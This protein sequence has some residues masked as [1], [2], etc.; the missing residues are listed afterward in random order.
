MSIVLESILIVLDMYWNTLDWSLKQLVDCYAF[1]DRYNRTRSEIQGLKRVDLRDYPEIA[2]REALLNA[3]VHKD[4]A[5]SS[6]ILIS[7][8]EDR[9]EI[10][11]IGGLIKGISADDLLLGI[12][13]LRNQYLADV[14]YRLKWV[15]AYG[16]GI[17][18]IMGSY[19]THE[20]TPKIEV[21][22]NV[23]KI[24]LPNTQYFDV[25]GGYEVYLNKSESTVMEMFE[26]TYTIK[27]VDVEA[28]LSVSQPM[29]VKILKSLQE[30]DRIIR[31]GSGKNTMYRQK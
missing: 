23:F 25:S 24:T 11:T 8:F 17:Q 20:I 10:V 1:L 21:S 5:L 30:K 22:S 14:F 13:M 12:S 9:M 27:R 4:Y 18:K 3:I 28:E 15:E 16:T 7:L 19:E 2:I 29:A 31:I 6:S 26:K